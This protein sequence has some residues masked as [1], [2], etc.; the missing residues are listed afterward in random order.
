M[1]IPYVAMPIYRTAK[2]I[3]VAPKDMTAAPLKSMIREFVKT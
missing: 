3:M 2:A 1:T